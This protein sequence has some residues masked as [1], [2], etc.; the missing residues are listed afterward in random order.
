[1]GAPVDMLGPSA[2]Q[3]VKRG[4]RQ[5][6]TFSDGLSSVEIHSGDPDSIATLAN[7]YLAWAGN[8]PSIDSIEISNDAG[9]AQC[10]VATVQDGAKVWQLFSN[11]L[12]LRAEQGPVGDGLTTDEIVAAYNA[13]ELGAT[14]T[15]A[16]NGTWDSGIAIPLSGNAKKLYSLLCKGEQTYQ[17]TGYVL[18]CS[19]QCSN[20]SNLVAAYSNVNKVDTPNYSSNNIIGSIPAGEWLKQGPIVR[21]IGA[22]RYEIQE[23]WWWAPKWSQVQYGGTGVP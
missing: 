2:G 18:R 23:E 7:A 6:W 11:Q 5:R 16:T 9:R 3:T 14:D 13:Y 22:R 10:L 17:F 20:R 15:Q 8:T 4:K 1:M 21:Q 19:Q 12:L